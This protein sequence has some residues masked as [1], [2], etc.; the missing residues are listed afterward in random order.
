MKHSSFSSFY[1]YDPLIFQLYHYVL[2]SLQ[3]CKEL[4]KI[5]LW[6]LKSEQEKQIKKSM[7][8]STDKEKHSKSQKVF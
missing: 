5:V 2:I 8:I 1:S 3:S 6:G 7:Q 4:I